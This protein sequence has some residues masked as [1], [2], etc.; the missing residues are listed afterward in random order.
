MKT[1]AAVG[2]NR[3]IQEGEAVAETMQE[4]AWSLIGEFFEKRET[5]LEEVK[6]RSKGDPLKIELA[7]ELRK[8]TAMPMA[9]IAKE[10]HAGASNSVW[11]ALS[12]RRKSNNV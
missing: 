4:K 7:G 3:E 8:H 2:A 5:G 12:K 10:F 6:V 9:C 11:N 1:G